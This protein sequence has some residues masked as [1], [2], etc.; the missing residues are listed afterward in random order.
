MSR[1]QVFHLHISSLRP[2]WMSWA[3]AKPPQVLCRQMRQAT[4]RNPQMFP[5]EWRRGPRMSGRC[6]D[7]KI[8]EWP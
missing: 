6:I 7:E 8:G 1:L 5:R 3:K 4:A 2:S